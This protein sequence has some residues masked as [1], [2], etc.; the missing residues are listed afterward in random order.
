MPT[1]PVPNMPLAEPRGI[2]E[3]LQQSAPLLMNSIFSA[4]TAQQKATQ[5]QNDAYTAGAAAG[6]ESV[7]IQAEQQIH[8]DETQL[9]LLRATGLDV[10]D[11]N[12]RISQEIARSATARRAREALDTRIGELQGKSLFSDPL[13]Y[14]A[15]QPELQQLIPQYNIYANQEN[16]AD[17][18]VERIRALAT[19]VI[20]KTPVRASALL[21]ADAA[22]KANAMAAVAQAQAQE[23][24]IKSI[25]L[26]GKAVL[27]AFNVNKEIFQGSL[28][29]AKATEDIKM[30]QVQQ[31]NLEIQ[32]GILNEQRALKAEEAATKKAQQELIMTG[33]NAI[34][35]MLTGDAHVVTL[36]EFQLWKKD[37][38]DAYLTR[39]GD[40]NFGPTYAQSIPFVDKYGNIPDA[41]NNGSGPFMRTVT[42]ISR[43]VAIEKERLQN[44][45]KA[46]PNAAKLSD[47]E[48]ED[49]AYKNIYEAD[50]LDAAKGTDRSHMSPASPYALDYNEILAAARAKAPD[51]IISKVLQEEA[52]KKPGGRFTNF[53]ERQLL[54]AMDGWVIAG[55][56][57][58]KTA[59]AEVAKFYS[60]NAEEN[61]KT[62]GLAQLNLPKMQDWIVRP[63]NGKGV[64]LIN[65]V[66]LENR[67]TSVS[68]NAFRTNNPFKIFSE[69]ASGIDPNVRG[70]LKSVQQKEQAAREKGMKP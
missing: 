21:R 24:N 52:A 58:P 48:A 50:K 69:G 57:D 17:A 67:F 4:D 13:G 1:T 62:F 66:E 6:G 51:S 5:L 41:V 68:T 59:A 45:A 31:A 70:V 12:S 34:Q 8:M 37:K 25:A 35:N 42:N 20:D 65:P 47:K 18:E 7:R 39:F 9:E 2:F 19:T 22:A 49:L 46:T 56:V 54:Q 61:Y 63:D 16:T 23:A 60:T 3:Q 38:Q 32:R 44:L 33:V 43:R 53:D 11:P 36:A 10:K 29:L 30:R 55:K 27:D 40:T 15:A 14:F 64:N 28:G 26:H